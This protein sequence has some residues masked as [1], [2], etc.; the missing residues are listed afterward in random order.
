MAQTSSIKDNWIDQLSHHAIFDLS[1]TE[2]KSLRD[3]RTGKQQQQQQQQPSFNGFN[4]FKTTTATATTATDSDASHRRTQQLALRG[5]DLFLAVGSHIRVLNLVDFKDAW[6]GAT[7]QLNQGNFNDIN[8]S[9]ILDIPH[10]ILETPGI[11]FVI[12]VII[13]NANGTLLAVA[14]E[15]RLAVVCLPRKGFS[16]QADSSIAIMSHQ[17]VACKTLLIGQ[18]FYNNNGDTRILKIDWHALSETGSHIVVLSNDSFLRMFD[19]SVDTNTPE[20]KFN[21]AVS[22]RKQPTTTTSFGI[23]ADDEMDEEEEVATF[24]LGG[25]SHDTSGWEPFTVYYALKNGHMYALCP[26][27]PFKSTVR[28]QHLESLACVS[29]TKCKQLFDNENGDTNEQLHPYYY[30]FAMQFSWIKDVL[31]TARTS[32]RIPRVMMDSNQLCIQ[33]DKTSIPL[34]VQP[35]GP[36]LIKETQQQNNPSV[37]SETSDMLLLQSSGFDIIALASTNGSIRNYLLAGGIGAQWILPSGKASRQQWH[38]E[39]SQIQASVAFLPR[40]SLYESINFAKPQNVNSP[41]WLTENPASNSTFYAYHAGGVHSVSMQNVVDH[42]SHMKQKLQSGQ[43]VASNNKNEANSQ[44]KG[45]VNTSP[46]EQCTV[47]P[48]IGVVIINDTFLSYCLLSLDANYRL[49]GVDMSLQNIINRAPELNSASTESLSKDSN[50]T[51]SSPSSYQPALSTSTFE[52]PSTL[53]KLTTQSNVSK[54]VI[55]PE[56]GGSKEVVITKDTLNF[57]SKTGTNIRQDIRDITKCASEMTSRLAMQRQ[58]YERQIT[59]LSELNERVTSYQSNASSDLDASIKSTREAHNQLA[60]R[61]E[62]MLRNIASEKQL[63]L[64]NK[65]KEWVDKVETMETELGGYSEK[66]EKL[67]DQLKS[68]RKTQEQ[69]KGKQQLLTQQK[70]SKRVSTSQASSILHTLNIQKPALDDLRHRMEQIKLPADTEA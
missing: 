13:P 18:D 59:T 36:F 24:T 17:K 4:Q 8:H 40:A 64:S 53:Q 62:R 69:L 51:T 19:V 1:V 27:L 10:K 39:L 55:P 35:Q 46:F 31:E 54:V 43:T 42:L 32:K 7:E 47:D 33:T 30:Y 50:N 9:D 44:V 48:I 23:S 60:V 28:R 57:L 5:N 6:I 38:K 58:E 3:L 25:P 20:Q 63:G 12:D 29:Q 26:V 21:L 37:H 49:I 41:I 45:L 11:D 34:R 67:D 61:I 2:G 70:K 66:M 68:Y 15:N 56:L 14:G 65:E 52:S 22:Q 16:S